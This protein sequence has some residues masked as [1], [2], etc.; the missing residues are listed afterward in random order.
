[1]KSVVTFQASTVEK[2]LEQGWHS[3]QS[4]KSGTSL[5]VV[6]QLAMQCR[7]T[8]LKDLDE[9]AMLTIFTMILAAVVLGVLAVAV[10]YLLGWADRVFQVEVDPKVEAILEALPGANCGGCS[11]VGCTDFADAVSKG[12]AEV[13][14]CGPG[15]TTSAQR[16][17]EI[18]GVETPDAFPYRA[19]VHC[20]ASGGQRLQRVPYL[21]EPTC[22]GANLVAGVQGCVYGCLGLGVRKPKFGG[23]IRTALR[24]QRSTDV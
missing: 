9:Q 24:N 23:P 10:G 21:G 16:I 2:T 3:P 6:H 19:V 15:G 18:M 13:N 8:D 1:V 17:A 11:F 5:A 14:L 20:G 7:E 4:A 22:A 12:K